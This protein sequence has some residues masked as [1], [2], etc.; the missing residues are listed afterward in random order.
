M[1]S[2]EHPGDVRLEVDS[3]SDG[4]TARILIRGEADAGSLDL[5]EAAL[6]RIVL[7]TRP[8]ICIDL[9]ELDF[10][11]VPALRLLGSFMARVRRSGH[12][13]TAV[14][15]RPALRRTARLLDP[16]GELGLG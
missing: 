5:L 2:T 9:S 6:D 12:A 4:S 7:D 1:A 10:V 15:A 11:D 16:E 13:V 14:G 8:T 3:I